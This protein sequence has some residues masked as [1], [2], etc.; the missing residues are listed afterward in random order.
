M[1]DLNILRSK[2][3]FFLN[4]L[5]RVLRQGI[6]SSVCFA[7]IVIN[8]EIITKKFLSL[9]DLSEAQTLYIYKLVEVVKVDKYKNFMLRAL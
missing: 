5:L 7:L 1:E 4:T 3:L 2:D 8:S 9:T 6:G